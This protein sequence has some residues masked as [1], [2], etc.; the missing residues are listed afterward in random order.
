MLR[1]TPHLRPFNEL[2]TLHTARRTFATNM[3]ELQVLSAGELRSLT[4]HESEQALL[5]YLNVDREKVAA[6]GGSTPRFE[7][8]ALRMRYLTNLSSTCSEVCF[9]DAVNLIESRP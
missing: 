9:L 2:V 5:L 8:E 7:N 4:G 1:D 6:T 3:W